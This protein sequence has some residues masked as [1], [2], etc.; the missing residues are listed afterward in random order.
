MLSVWFVCYQPSEHNFG[1][2]VLLF[3]G[4]V[5]LAVASTNYILERDETVDVIG[6]ML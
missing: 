6:L 2:T 5:L 4:K 1:Q 3:F